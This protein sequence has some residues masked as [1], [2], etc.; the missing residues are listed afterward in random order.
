MTL[1]V[2]PNTI[3]ADD[4]RT[5]FAISGT[6][7]M[8]G[9]YRNDSGPVY[10]GVYGYPHGNV[11]EP[12]TS[13]TV[14]FDDFHGATRYVPQARSVTLYA[15]SSSWTVPHTTVGNLTIRAFGGGGGGAR[16]PS[17]AAGGAGG[18]GAY[19]VGSISR[20]TSISYTVASGGPAVYGDSSRYA[21]DAGNTQF[22]VAGDN[23]YMYIPGAGTG[24]WNMA[25]SSRGPGTGSTAQGSSSVTKGVGGNGS[26][27]RTS[28]PGGNATTIGGGGGG[29]A[30]SNGGSGAYGG[31]N[32]GNAASVGNWPG[33]GAGGVDAGW[34]YAGADGAIII[35]GTW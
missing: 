16:W 35:E 30:W 9:L 27:E 5:E 18:G 24:G 32:G 25:G 21:R 19:F 2:Y 13:G 34:S 14:S 8:N 4:I 3:S 1:P 6:L 17:G 33:G 11:I 26:P 10:T 23:W 20:G 28:N 29:C 12:A 22:G 15:G 31:G 7:S